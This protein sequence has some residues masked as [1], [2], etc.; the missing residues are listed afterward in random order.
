MDFETVFFIVFFTLVLPAAWVFLTPLAK[1]YRQ[2]IEQPPVSPEVSGELERLQ[3]RVTE[4]EERLDFAERLLSQ[5]REAA[6]V[7]GGRP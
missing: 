6:R 3:S 4:L 1:R 2:R 7:S 5:Q